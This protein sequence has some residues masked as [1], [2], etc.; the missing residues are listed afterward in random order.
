M[1]IVVI[2]QQSMHEFR[3]NFW[4]AFLVAFY[5]HITKGSLEIVLNCRSNTGTPQK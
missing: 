5:L 2:G 1:F 4:G 3:A